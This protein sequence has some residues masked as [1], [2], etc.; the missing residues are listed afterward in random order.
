MMLNWYWRRLSRM[1]LREVGW[2]ARDMILRRIWR[3]R[4]VALGAEVAKRPRLHRSLFV[5]ALPALNRLSLPRSAVNRLLA[6]AQA[7]LDERWLVFG[8]Q[9]PEFGECPDWFV[10][11]QS[12]RHAPRD[13]YAFDIPYR[14]EQ[15]IGNIKYIW[16][17]S[18]HHHL[19]ILATA[20]ALTGDEAYAIRIADHLHSWWSENPFLSGPH[21]ISGIEVG[22]RLIAWVWTR[23]ML[24]GWPKAPAL[25]EEN[26][27][28]LD[29]LYHHQQWLAA[30]PSRASSANNHLIAEAAG[31]FVAACAFPCFNESSR[32]RERSAGVL[33]HE[34]VAQTFPSGLN[35]ELATDYHGLVMELFLTAAVEGELSGQSLGPIAWERIRAMTDALAAIMDATGNP[36]R[37]GDGDDGVGILLDA[38]DYNRWKALLSTGQRLFGALSWWPEQSVDDLRTFLWTCNVTTPPLPQGRPHVRPAIFRDAGHVYL[39]DG[40]GDK[41]IWCRC[42][43]GPHGFLSIAAH[44]HADA[45]S[46]ELRVGGVQILADPGTYCYY[47]DPAWRAYFRSTIGH[48]TLELMSRDQS[49]SGGPFLWTNHAQSRL[50]AVE[51]LDEFA[52][53]ARWQAE[54]SGYVSRGGPIHRRTVTLERTTR[55]LTICDMIRGSRGGSPPARLAFHLGPNVACRLE[56]GCAMLSWPGGSAELELSQALN[57][58]LHCGQVNPPLGWFS[59]SFVVKKSTV[60]LLG[61][62]PALEG[63]PIVS[64]LRII[65][66]ASE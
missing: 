25:F 62:N 14:D 34:V 1:G 20:Y 52:P 29:Q 54:H 3:Y 41:E 30:F 38:P 4:R 33:R 10:D 23:R 36:P 21:W 11:A 24:Q 13:H 12:G 60:T 16:E 42:D 49:V 2:R 57:W 18:R 39:R 51:G 47:G 40:R 66:I 53:H 64:R 31:Q 45:L 55:V 59:P 65:R 58:T 8:H 37:Q 61:V 43:H 28:F 46:V 5:G 19:T 26:P 48:N 17:P 27:Q 63:P 7:L 22:I 15:R 32:W 6:V 56:L 35:R 9:H 50:I 44:A